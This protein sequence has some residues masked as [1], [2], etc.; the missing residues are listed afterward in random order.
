LPVRLHDIRIVLRAIAGRVRRR[1]E[2]AER[3][4]P[5][6]LAGERQLL[7]AQRERAALAR[8]LAALEAWRVAHLA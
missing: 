5:V 2:V 6:G 1:A 7:L 8:V 3:Q 4:L